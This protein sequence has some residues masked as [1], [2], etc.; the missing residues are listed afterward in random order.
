MPTETPTEPAVLGCD[1]II[2]AT[3]YSDLSD[4]GWSAIEEPLRIGEHLLEDGIQCV[5]GDYSSGT[6][7][8]QM[9]GWAPVGS[10]QSRELQDYLEQQG[11]IREEEGE[12]VYLTENPDY[13][14]YVSED[15]YGMTFRF[16]EGSVAVAD[17]K[18]GLQLVIWRG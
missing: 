8:A 16:T 18:S 6:D 13:A 3:L 14:L 10:E 1:T 11:W 9:Y 4:L 2:P 17:T 5:W 15:G 12:T 7:I